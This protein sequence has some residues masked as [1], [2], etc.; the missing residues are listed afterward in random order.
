L[1]FIKLSYKNI[2][3]FL[4]HGTAIGFYTGKVIGFATRNKRCATYK[5][6]ERRLPDPNNNSALDEKQRNHDC[7]KDFEGSSKVME[8][9]MACAIFLHNLHFEEVNVRLG[10]LIGDDDSCT[11]S[12]LR[13]ETGYEIKKWSDKNH[14][15]TKLSKCLYSIKLSTT[16]VKYFKYCFSCVLN[17]NKNNT[18]VIRENFLNIVP[19]AFDDHSKFGDWCKYKI[20]P[21][22]YRHKILPGGKGL[23]EKGHINREKIQAVFEVFSRNAEKLNPCGSTQGNESLNHTIAS[24]APKHLHYGGSS[25]NDI[26]VSDSIFHKSIG[27]TTIT[28]INQ[29]MKNSPTTKSSHQFRLKKDKEAAL[30]KMKTQTMQFKRRR[31]Q[32]FD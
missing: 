31:R 28:H 9:D 32:L 25:S 24:R 27:I 8:A 23:V 1:I 11:I 14:A 21:V 13:K 4:S 29:K 7:R 20:D 16:L 30:R 19:H 17:K 3:L 26:R 12:T 15:V 10:T 5:S 18:E 6:I 22:S 2:F